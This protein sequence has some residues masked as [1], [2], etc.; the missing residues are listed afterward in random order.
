MSQLLINP[1]RIA[2][3]AWDSDLQALFAAP[4]IRLFHQS[5]PAFAP[6]PLV[7]LKGLAASLGVGEILVKDES[8][9][10]GLKAFKVLGASYATFRHLKQSC[11]E[12]TGVEYTIEHFH[13]RKHRKILGAQ[14]FCTATDGNHGRAVAWT[15]RILG[16]R[17]VIFMPS[18][19]VQARIDAIKGE[20]AEIRIVDGNYDLAVITAQEAAESNGWQ[21]ISDTSYCGYLKIPR[22]IMAGYTTMFQEITEQLAESGD[23]LI[24]AVFIQAGVGALA[25]AAAFCYSQSEQE[26]TLI[27]V[28]P[29]HADCLLTS[30]NS[31]DGSLHSS[32]GEQDSIMAGLNCGTPSLIAWPLIRDRFDAFLSMPDDYSLEA[33]RKYYSPTNADPRIISGESGAAGLAALLAL[34]SDPALRQHLDQL[35]LGHNSRILLLNTEGDTDPENFQNVIS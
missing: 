19:S 35:N 7:R 29:T 30:A 33:M 22:W 28:E 21:I 9:R 13:Q 3:P 26:P 25:A 10:L 24:D 2:Q 14:T 8:Q 16:E 34:T 23:A 15:A 20:G 31:E 4:E 1:H 32:A 12:R 27:S 17:A 5:L 18:G 11:E 6:T